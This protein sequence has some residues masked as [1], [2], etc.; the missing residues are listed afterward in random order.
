[1]ARGR[2]GRVQPGTGSFSFPTPEVEKDHTGS[3]VMAWRQKMGQGHSR[4]KYCR[5]GSDLAM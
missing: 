2:G 5:R 3:T 1:M 4:I